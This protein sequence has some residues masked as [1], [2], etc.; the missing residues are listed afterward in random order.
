MSWTATLGVVAG[1]LSAVCYVPYIRDI[2]RGTTKPE[3]ATWFIWSVLTLILLFAQLAKGA[4]DSIWLT[5]VQSLGV[6]VIFFLSLKFGEGGL[7]R[8]DIIA[9][10][11]AAIGLGVWFV[12]QE[13]AFALWLTIAI[14][15]AGASLTILKAYE[16]PESE[17]QITWF[18]S[19]LAGVF[20][21]LAVGSWS[22]NLLAFPVYVLIVNFT[23]F[24]AIRLGFA[25]KR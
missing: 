17:T 6:V 21:A 10:I 12:T 15:F 22:L 14:D 4:T 9:L 24:G 7:Q 8:R 20:A 19:G 13:A 11:A 25:R 23:V 3:R 1:V 18:L 5:V 2:F 16:E